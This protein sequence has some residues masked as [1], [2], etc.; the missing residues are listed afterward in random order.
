MADATADLR[1][2]I[3]TGAG[4]KNGEPDWTFLALASVGGSSQGVNVSGGGL[5]I[6]IM[7][8]VIKDQ[9]YEI[10]LGPPHQAAPL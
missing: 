5:D 3:E 4:E 7:L 9:G 2:S 8:S 6:H 1:K 10:I